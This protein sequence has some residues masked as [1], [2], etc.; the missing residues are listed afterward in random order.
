MDAPMNDLDQSQTERVGYAKLKEGDVER[1]HGK[2]IKHLISKDRNWIVYRD[3]DL[4]VFWAIDDAIK[5]KWVDYPAFGET[6]NEISALEA[7]DVSNLSKDQIA[8][9]R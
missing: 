2:T 8:S 1:V 4:S 3:P 7:I 9:F 6:V 5:S